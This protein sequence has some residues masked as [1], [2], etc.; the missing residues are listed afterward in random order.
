MRREK[1][2]APNT[3]GDEKYVAK[4]NPFRAVRPPEEHVA[5]VSAPPYDVV[6]TEEA[7]VLA[8]GNPLSFLH[9]SRPEIDLAP[10]VDLYS[11]QVYEKAA[12]NYEKLKRECPLEAEGTPSIYLYKLVMGG[13]E[14]IGVVACASVDEYDN[15]L[16][17]KHEKTRRDK[18]D[19]RTRHMIALRAQTGPVFL[20]IVRTRRSIRSS[21]QRFPKNRSMIS[22]L[23]MA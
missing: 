20:L 18:E 12:E 1:D 3:A 17:K 15:D 23:L 7:R 21:A 5:A 11:D 2:G 13:H 16:I 4:L 14:Q 8:R 6:S 19:D 9:V 22:R 10:G